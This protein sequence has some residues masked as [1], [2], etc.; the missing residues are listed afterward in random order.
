[1]RCYPDAPSG[2]TQLTCSNLRTVTCSDPDGSN[3]D[4]NQCNFGTCDTSN[5]FSGDT[6]GDIDSDHDPLYSSIQDITVAC[7]DDDGNGELDINVCLSWRQPGANELCTAPYDAYPG[8]PSKCRCQALPGIVIPVPGQI[9]VDKVTIDINGNPSPDDPTLFDFELTNVTGTDPD[10][11]VAFQLAGATAP[12]QSP[13]LDPAQTY[14]LKEASQSGWTLGFAECISDKGN[15]VDLMGGGNI[16]V[17][18]GETF[19]CTFTNYQDQPLELDFGDAPDSYGTLLPNGARHVIVPGYSLGPIVDAEPDGQPSTLAD[20][21]DNNPLGAPDD[22]DGVNF[23]TALISGDPATVT[24]DGGL[25]GGMLDAWID[26]NGNGTFDHPAEHLWGGTSQALISGSNNL[27]FPVPATAVQGSTYARF[28]LSMNGGLAPTGLAP[29]GEVEDYRVQI[30]F[31]LGDL[32]WYDSD[33]DGIHEPGEPGVAG[34]GVELYD[35]GTCSYGQPIASYTT[36]AYGYYV[37]ASLAGT[38]CIQFSN[39]PAGVAVSPQDMGGDDT[40]DSDANP[41]T[42]QITDIDLTT[43]DLDEDMGIYEPGTII[44]READRA[45]M[46]QTAELFEF[47]T[48]YQGPTLLWPWT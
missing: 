23:L 11:P 42:I 30:E 25:S 34:V 31:L 47:S 1:M 5:P 10:L 12:Y 45:L 27:T 41:A 21:D 18:S 33:A 38:Y 28:R 15:M 43:H 2:T 24:M 20:G 14:N 48:S 3:A 36:D 46:V 35:N 16:T 8:S 26:F 7:I 44:H 22:E 40:I 37:F 29:D 6:C 9:I 39:L 17:N 19:N 13:G 32:V 4:L